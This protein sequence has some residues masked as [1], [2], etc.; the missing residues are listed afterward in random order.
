MKINTF[1][2]F[3]FI[4]GWA[5]NSKFW[6]NLLESL[7][8]QAPELIDLGFTHNTTHSIRQNCPA[9]DFLL[10][11]SLGA[12]WAL[13]NNI[14]PQKGLVIINGFHSFPSFAS[15]ETLEAMRQGLKTNLRA[16]VRA[17]WR[18]AGAEFDSAAFQSLN[19]DALTEGLDWLEKWDVKEALTQLECPVLVL[20]GGQ[21]LIC[22]LE[23]MQDHW[24]G[25][26]MLVN[27]DAGHSLPQSHPEWC[28][29]MISIWMN[30]I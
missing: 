16:Q 8:T 3:C 19:T 24:K 9:P 2:S 1:Q 7:D 12:L 15:P 11:H 17:F 28:Q 20:A 18:Q 25:Y 21:D 14:R 10:T 23:T 26:D 5:F 22:P 6:A 29:Q 4:H 30:T 13:E 27:K